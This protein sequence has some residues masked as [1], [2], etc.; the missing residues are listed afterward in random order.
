MGGEGVSEQILATCVAQ[1]WRCIGDEGR[2]A[3]GHVGTAR[4]GEGRIA[5]TDGVFSTENVVDGR[6]Q[7][8]G[9]VLA[10]RLLAA[11]GLAGVV[12]HTR[13]PYQFGTKKQTP[14][15]MPGIVCLVRAPI[16]RVV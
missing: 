12:G 11:I 13:R 9:Q 1:L 3:I 8:A 10:P 5:H 2:H 7:P 4:D 6:A 16:V 14:D 15:T